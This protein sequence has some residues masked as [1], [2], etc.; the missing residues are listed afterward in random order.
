M[1]IGPGSPLPLKHMARVTYDRVLLLDLH[2]LPTYNHVSCVTFAFTGLPEGELREAKFT[3][4][5]R[6]TARE[7][8]IYAELRPYY[9][10]A[11]LESEVDYVEE[12]R[13]TTAI[14]DFIKER[15]KAGVPLDDIPQDVVENFKSRVQRRVPYVRKDEREDNPPPRSTRRKRPIISSDPDDRLPLRTLGVRA[16][17]VVATQAAIPPIKTK[18]TKKQPTQK[19]A[20]QI[21]QKATPRP[22]LPPL[23]A[24]T[25]P[26]T[27]SAPLA[28]HSSPPM[29]PPVVDPVVLATAENPIILEEYAAATQPLT[30]SPLF[31]PTALTAPAR[32]PTA[33]SRKE[34]SDVAKVLQALDSFTQRADKRDKR[35]A[36]SLKYLIK[37]TDA[38]ENEVSEIK[39][40][41]RC[42]AGPLVAAGVAEEARFPLATP[43]EVENYIQDDPSLT[44]ATARL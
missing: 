44:R 26:C 40:R 30:S 37:K 19:V 11:K 33:N 18:K 20:T 10:I 38:I 23:P 35:L 42:L 39:D 27:S 32:V 3:P 13:A 7:L 17:N 14:N 29:T 15:R 4:D 16:N 22:A 8:P 1:Q 36:D 12:L 2:P 25:R 9:I 34:L 31:L 6:L 5:F 43:E 21:V 24:I 28:R 41:L